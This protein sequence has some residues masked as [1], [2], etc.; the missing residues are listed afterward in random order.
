VSVVAADLPRARAV[1]ETL[2]ERLRAAPD[3]NGVGLMRR[4]DGWP[5]KVNLVRPCASSPSALPH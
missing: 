2:T 5:V 4:P 3:V 1:K